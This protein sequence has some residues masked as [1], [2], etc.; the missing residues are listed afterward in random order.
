MADWREQVVGQPKVSLP[1]VV[2]V[3]VNE[4]DVCAYI[5]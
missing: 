5:H 3:V 4:A 2:W 1:D